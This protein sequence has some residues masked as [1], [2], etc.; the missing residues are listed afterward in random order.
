MSSPTV[1]NT[2]TPN[3]QF[4]R[5]IAPMPSAPRPHSRRGQ[6]QPPHKQSPVNPSLTDANPPALQQAD[7]SSRRNQA[8]IDRLAVSIINSVNSQVW[9]KDC[10]RADGLN[11]NEWIDFI[12]ARMRDA[13]GVTYFFHHPA[14]NQLHERIGRSVM[15]NSL[16]RSLRRSL[17]HVANSHQM[18][19]TLR[20]RFHMLSQASMLNL[21]RRLKSFTVLEKASTPEIA[22]EISDIFNDINDM[23]VPYTRDVWAGLFLQDAL[24]SVPAIQEEFD[25]RLE[26]EYQTATP[27][28]PPMGFDGMVTLIDIV[29]TQLNIQADNQS[30]SQNT[31]PLAMRADALPDLPSANTQQFPTAHNNQFVHPNNVP[32]AF[33]FMAMQAGLCWQC[34][35]PD[36]P[37]RD[38]PLRQHPQTTCQRFQPR[39]P[40]TTRQYIPPPA[41][42]GFQPFY[43]IVAPPGFVGIYPQAQGTF[44]GNRPP[45]PSNFSPSNFSPPQAA[46]PADNCQPQD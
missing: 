32:D 45:V 18:Y 6:D 34:R 2:P 29:R 1:T 17:Q 20:S 39:A 13:T 9:D 31:T 11:W 37:L 38:C 24:R 27:E 25:C 4:S 19:Q 14:T 41:Q 44:Q 42:T 3:N 46:R 15:L 8:E 28:R 26:I 36:H 23:G 40:A 16:V 43:L 35:S 5:D 22:T 7:S 30:T 21:F 10:L 12:D 33:D